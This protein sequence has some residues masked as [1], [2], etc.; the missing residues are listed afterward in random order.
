MD[1][2]TYT[3]DSDLGKG[4][5][6]D[7]QSARIGPLQ[8]TF[9]LPGRNRSGGTRVT[10]D[11]ANALIQRG[12]RVRIAHRRSRGF[13]LRRLK[14]EL[15]EMPRRLERAILHL[16]GW[17]NDDWV[18]TF[19]GPI[20]AYRRLDELRFCPGEAVIAV[21]SFTVEDVRQLHQDV[22]KIRY[23]H[24]FQEDRPEWMREVWSGSMATI[25]VA[26]TIV[27]RLEQY[28]GEKVVD[29][30][31][32]GIHASEYYPEQ[33]LRDGIGTIYGTHSAKAPEF[34]LD[35]LDHISKRWPGVPRYVFGMGPRPRSIPR[36]QYW[37][38][39]SVEKAREL[40]NRSKVWLVTSAYEGFGLPILEAMA[41]GCAVVS[42]ETLGA[43]ELVEDGRNGLLVPVGGAEAFLGRIERL[44]CDD[45]Y[46]LGLVDAGGQTARRFRW[47]AA[48]AKME[49]VL[50]RLM[51]GGGGRQQA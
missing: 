11:M 27:P 33:R 39:P 22:V 31:P 34:T 5:E 4:A 19:K 42:T 49:V 15:Q 12:H 6:G 16:G 2:E 23:C 10:V 29:V 44:L 35:L 25:A 21:A 9:V 26:R 24:G 32:N 3:R 17:S 50:G 40:Y 48:A 7:A 41:C 38:L 36:S 47:E 30:V 45:P 14:R 43:L 13:Q 37:H 51:S 1:G 46:R 28:S 20:D 18:H 8:I